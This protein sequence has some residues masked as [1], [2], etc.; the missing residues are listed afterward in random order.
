[1]KF[2]SLV[3]AFAVAANQFSSAF[4]VSNGK[5]QDTT[6]NGLT[7]LAASAEDVIKP[8]IETKTVQSDVSVSSV[9]DGFLSIWASAGPVFDYFK[10]S[11][12]EQPDFNF[13]KDFDVDIDDC[14]PNPCWNGGCTDTGTDSYSC[15]CDSGWTGDD[16][17]VDIDDCDPNPCVNG[18]CSDTGT[19]S[20]SCA[21]D[22]GW[23][24]DDCDVDIDDC[25]P[26][27]CVNGG[28]TDT[29]TD[30]YSCACDSGWTGDDCD[31]CAYTV[32][33]DGTQD[34]PH[35]SWEG[36]CDWDADTKTECAQ[37][38]CEADSQFDS[39]S[40]ISASN[41]MC[42][43]GFINDD[44]WHWMTDLDKYDFNNWINEAQITA[45]C[46]LG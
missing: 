32:V 45:C 10:P 41:N 34:Q 31:V 1:M 38:L 42:N 46:A 39:G 29:G 30:S 16:C 7:A 11:I 19:D 33:S 14:D 44:A 43:S 28:C 8:V 21:C 23:R 25:D 15:A 2:T 20:Y 17:D 22:S 24:G 3:L 27:P 5:A 36:I 37:K 35:C 26:N 13:G 18:D 6:I 9:N 4:A 40:F 12:N